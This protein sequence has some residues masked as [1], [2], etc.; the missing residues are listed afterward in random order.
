MRVVNQQGF[1]IHCEV[2]NSTVHQ[3]ADVWPREPPSDK[4]GLPG[5]RRYWAVALAISLGWRPKSQAVRLFL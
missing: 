3:K 1:G 4:P 5:I 2:T